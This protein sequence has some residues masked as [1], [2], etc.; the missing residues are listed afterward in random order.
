M[1]FCIQAVVDIVGP[2]A[3]NI[4]YETSSYKIFSLHAMKS[5]NNGGGTFYLPLLL[6]ESRDNSVMGCFMLILR[7]LLNE[8]TTGPRN[9]LLQSSFLA[10]LQE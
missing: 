10:G 9:S 5:L 6:F 4:V 8:Y 7:S 2:G 3:A 1:P